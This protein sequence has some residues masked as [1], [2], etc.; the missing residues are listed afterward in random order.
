[1]RNGGGFTAKDAESAK[2]LRIGF[3]LSLGGAMDV[4]REA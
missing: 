1:M 4:V 3:E 2:G